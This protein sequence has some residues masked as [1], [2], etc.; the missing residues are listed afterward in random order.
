MS[1][2][3]TATSTHRVRSRPPSSDGCGHLVLERRL[4]DLE[5]DW[6]AYK[7]VRRPGAPRHRRSRSAAAATPSS[8][9]TV[10]TPEGL[11]LPLL[12]RSP[13]RLVWSLQQP[14]S[15]A[16]SHA[17][18]AAKDKINQLGDGA[19]A[20]PN[21]EE[22]A[23]SVC[24]VGGGYSV[25]VAT[26]SSSSCS[27]ES[28]CPYQR[29]A[30]CYGYSGSSSC[31]GATAPS[32]PLPAGGINGECARKMCEGTWWVSGRVLWIS[33]IALLVVGIVTMA[34]LEV[35]V[36]EGGEEYLVPT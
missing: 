4:L 22:D 9:V 5:R 35:G 10:A 7:T 18:G 19:P 25:G 29:A 28:C 12:R 16:E 20:G 32:F 11:L 34:I 17:D 23:S 30:L 3:S 14:T 21:D 13:R 6:D 2:C 26:S 31:N 1:T 15:S 24:S 36:D 33:A 8:A 27:C